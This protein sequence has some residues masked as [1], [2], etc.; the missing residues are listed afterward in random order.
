MS[1]R[2]AALAASLVGAW[3][4]LAWEIEYPA[5]GRRT[6]PFG[7][8]PEGLLLYTADGCMSAA[9]QRA[10][11]TPLSSERLGAVPA[12]EKAATFADCLHYAGRWRVEDTVVLHEVEVAQNPGLIG[13][14][15]LRNARLDGGLLELEAVEW[16]AATG[17]Q[18]VHH[19]RWRRHAASMA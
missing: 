2:D 14:R 11:R 18:R 13:T 5:S 8:Q 16:L 6:R 10:G 9:I 1:L 12:E 7:E 15:Q 17:E 3:R 4:L 19:I